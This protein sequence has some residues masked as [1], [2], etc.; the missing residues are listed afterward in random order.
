MNPNNLLIIGLVIFVLL[1]S[2]LF[3]KLYRKKPG[4]QKLSV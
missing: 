3:R 2:F 1:I 4:K